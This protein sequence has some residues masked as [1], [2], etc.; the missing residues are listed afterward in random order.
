MIRPAQLFIGLCLVLL[1]AMTCSRVQ[2]QTQCIHSGLAFKTLQEKYGETIRARAKTE[3]G[4][5]VVVLVSPKGSWTI[6]TVVE[7]LACYEASGKEWTDGE[8]S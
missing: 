1:F 4:V 7:G 2:A 5:D 3:Q 8:K 6:V